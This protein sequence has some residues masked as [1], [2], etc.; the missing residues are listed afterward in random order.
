MAKKILIAV[1]GTGGHVFPARA[2]ANELSKISED[3][4]IQFV[5]GELSSN[6]Y[7]D[8][9]AS[10]YQ[11]VACATM[12]GRTAFQKV[13]GVTSIAK[14]FLQSRKLLKQW[15]PD[16]I[17][18]FGSY[19]TLPILMA[20]RFTSIPVILHEGNRVAGRV[21][22]KFAKHARV[23]GTQ[24]PETK[25][26]GRSLEVGMP[27]REGYTLSFGSK[28]EARKKLGLSPN[29]FTFLVFGGSQGA[30]SINALFCSA[31][32][33]VLGERTTNFQV[34]HYTG[35]NALVEE[36]EQEYEQHGI[37]ATVKEFEG[38]MD[39][40]WQAA[41]LAVTR[42]GAM[43]IAELIEFEVPSLLIPYPHATDD[44]QEANADFVVELGGAVKLKE[45]DLEPEHLAHVVRQLVA[46]DQEKL[47]TMKK[48]LA[49]HK[50]E[51]R[52]RDLSSVVCEVA[53]VRRR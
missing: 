44:H 50:E 49:S 24:F 9:Q 11:E 8:P 43:T 6:R 38:R 52:P 23:V 2:L 12:A 31:L 5:G 37:R 15:R 45:A 17:V 51:R 36:F 22:R 32:T 10:S 18:G 14:G 25:V 41:D 7:F 30:L 48:A 29:R 46:N 39:L 13:A 35:K 4:E 40:A 20:A 26:E 27:L 47:N 19:H 34:L 16:V 42:A 33:H 28:Q 21:N 3:I 1:G 53:G